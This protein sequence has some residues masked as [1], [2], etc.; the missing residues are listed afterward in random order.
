[1]EQFKSEVQ[2]C[3]IFPLVKRVV[4]LPLTQEVPKL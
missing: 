2:E 1:G 3:L 4:S